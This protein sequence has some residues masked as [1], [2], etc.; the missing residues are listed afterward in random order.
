MLVSSSS[1]S[2]IL[3]AHGIDPS[4]GRTHSDNWAAFLESSAA[5][6]TAIDVTAV[7]VLVGN[8]LVTQWCVMAIHH[9]THRVELVGITEHLT[10]DWM[11]QQARNLTDPDHGFQR[12]RRFLL[13]DRGPNFSAKFR[14]TLQA[15]GVEAVRTPPQS[16]NCNPFIERFFR[17]LKEECLSLTIPFGQAGLR[18]L[19]TEYLE[20][21]HGERPHAGL[22]GQL[23]DPDPLVTHRSGPIVCR[24]RLGGLLKFYYRVAA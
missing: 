4:P 2:R 5:Q 13:M 6:I 14:N 15:V 11:L 10:E 20:H 24:Q 19:I 18:H 17:S 21:Y 16:P 9:D 8:S 23:I 3:R 22:G 7:E 12:D 1:V